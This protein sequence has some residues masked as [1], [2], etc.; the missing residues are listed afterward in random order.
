MAEFN[1]ASP[2]PSTMRTSSAITHSNEFRE[3]ARI[4]DETRRSKHRIVLECFRKPWLKILLQ[5]NAIEQIAQE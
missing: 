5:K 1:K 2:C 3:L 4:E